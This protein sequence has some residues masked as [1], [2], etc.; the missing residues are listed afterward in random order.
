VFSSRIRAGVRAGLIAAAATG[1]AIV[2]FGV[3]HN[4]WLGPFTTLGQQV[5]QG[6]GVAGAPRLIPTMTGLVAHVS[7]MVIWGIAFAVISYRKTPAITLLFAL[8][9]AVGAALLARSVVPA[10]MGATRF[11][12]MPGVQAALC[13]A[14]MAAGLVMGRAVTRPE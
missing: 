13:F 2:G 1:G 9:V 3:R 4:D 6:F 14:L 11:A 12:A 7:W 10:A 5:L 8:L